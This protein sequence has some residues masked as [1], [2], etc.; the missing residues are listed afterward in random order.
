MR[1]KYRAWD[2]KWKRWILPMDIS[3]WGNLGWTF[4]RRAKAD[5]DIIETTTLESGEID[6]EQ[7]T[8]L[9]D[10]NGVDI[11]EGDIL[12]F[13]YWWFDGGEQHTI[14]NGVVGFNTASFTLDQINNEWFQ[15]YTGYKKGEGRL[16]LGELN[17]CECDC[18][19]LGNIHEN[20]EL[21]EAR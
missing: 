19:V 3:F 6:L 10:K 21:I 11:Y 2:K 17:F 4:E 12:E 9:R 16:W 18:E 15:N 7:F 1:H 14:L 5:S 13:A 20:P 8:G